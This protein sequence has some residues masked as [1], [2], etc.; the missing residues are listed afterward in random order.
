MPKQILGVIE[1]LDALREELKSGRLA[2]T[3]EYDDVVWKFVENYESLRRAALKGEAGERVVEAVKES[4]HVIGSS[5]KL[6]EAMSA[7]RSAVGEE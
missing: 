5:W 1:E 2:Y 4:R 6:A 3:D 7:Y